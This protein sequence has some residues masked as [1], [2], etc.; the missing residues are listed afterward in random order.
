MMRMSFGKFRGGLVEDLP[1]D[2]LTWLHGLELR[3]PLKS[4]VWTGFE[5]RFSTGSTDE[6]WPLDVRTM[7]GEL[8]S[9]GLR[10]LALQHHPDHGG[11]TTTMQLVNRAAD[12]LRQAA[13]RAT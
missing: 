8:I 6:D 9:A 11:E 12:F 10:K 2:Y 1:D 13:R 7:A 3:D 4:A 5:L